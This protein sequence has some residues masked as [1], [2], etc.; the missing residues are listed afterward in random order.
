MVMFEW[1]GVI[2]RGAEARV[3]YLRG[4]ERQCDDPSACQAALA[5]LTS[6]VIGALI[7]L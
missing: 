1:S 5:P 6:E 4:K 7:G 3:D 2:V